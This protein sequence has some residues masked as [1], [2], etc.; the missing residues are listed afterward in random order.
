[1][2]LPQ[3]KVK[4]DSIESYDPPSS[5]IS[6]SQGATVPSGQIFSVSTGASFSGVVTATSFVGDG[7]NLSNL[8]V[9]GL[10]KA[11]SISLVTN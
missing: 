6:L 5:S 3:S 7:S 9:V 10:S 11:I 4:V 1:M 8:S 2:T